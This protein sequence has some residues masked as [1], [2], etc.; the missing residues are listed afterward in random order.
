MTA[1]EALRLAHQAGISISLVGD[2]I[3]YQSH[4]SPPAHALDALKAAKPEI[5]ALLSRYAL[6]EN[7]A[8]T[9]DDLLAGLVRSDFS[10]R[11]Y[12][13]Q[14][15]L[16]DNAVQGRAPPLPVL[17]RFAE[18]QIEYG[19]ALRAMRVPEALQQIA[20]GRCPPDDPPSDLSPLVNL[21]GHCNAMERIT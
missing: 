11:R 17:R 10:V 16:D 5:V 15:A 8:L 19:L 9:G 4:A 13:N 7:G 20:C 14:A 2:R 6:T 18:K 1:A 12:G 3:R 21:I